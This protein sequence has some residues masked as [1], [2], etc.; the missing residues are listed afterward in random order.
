LIKS[1]RC[2]EPEIVPLQSLGV[3]DV[4]GNNIEENEVLAHAL[5]NVSDK[6]RAEGWGVKR[7]GRFVNEYPRVTAEGI[8]SAGT[9][10]D[11]NH[12]LGTLPCLFPYGF[13][14]FEVDRPIQVSYKAHCQWALR[15]NDKRFRRD[16][17]FMFQVFGVLQKRQVCSAAALQ[18]SKTS[19][20]RHERAIRALKPSDFDLAA[21]EENAHKSFSNPTI[22]SLRH[23]LSAVRSKVMGTDESR[24][25]IRSLIWGMC[26]MK[27]PPSIW[28]TINPADT[29]DPIAQVLCGED[30]D[31]DDFI[32]CAHAR[33]S[34]VAVASDPYAAASFFH[35]MV[36][37]ILECLLGIKGYKRGQPVRREKGILGIVE[38]YIG[39]VEAQGRG[40]LH[41][42]MVLWL[43][44]AMPSDDMKERLSSENFRK[45][46]K[47]FISANVRA[48]LPNVHGTDVL[49]IPRQTRVAFSHPVDPRI[50]HY[51][52]QRADAEKRLART[53][54]VHQCG[55]GCIKLIKGRFVCKRKAP[56]AL[57]DDDWVEADGNWGPKRTYGYLNSWCPAVL[58]TLRANNDIKV[59]TN[60]K[61]TKNIAWYITHYVA[62]KQNTSSNTSALLAKT[63][64]YQRA[65]ESR[66]FDLVSKNKKLIQ[67][68]SNSLSRQ[69]EVS[70]P[71]AATY[72]MEWGDRYISHHFE[73]IHWYSV[74][75]LLKK[76]FP[77]LDKHL[78]VFFFLV[79]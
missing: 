73:T 23:T 2:V 25:K 41:L 9:P 39:T 51:E 53:V 43:R 13:G 60:G 21:A 58:Q 61:E 5:V 72:L 7:G 31:L 22:Q 15:Y 6:D 40:T 52:E 66:N 33:P 47:S 35:L 71:E 34:D 38:A 37:A 63:F 69:Q 76:T 14:G 8:R 46:I 70:G 3:V 57:A 65:R 1:Y 32:N 44:G 78:L 30:L 36:N 27:N 10:D 19:F 29:Q 75:S 54:Q 59:M 18:I 56:F 17:F 16:H 74:S 50:P 62:K 42:H 68:C 67:G 20:L 45:K 48:D 64:A 26:M 11:P 24:I 28:M 77:M 55:Q 12:L 79:V 4:A 49:S